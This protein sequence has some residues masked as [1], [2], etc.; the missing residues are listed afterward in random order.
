MTHSWPARNPNLAGSGALQATVAGVGVV[1][2]GG[3]LAIG[4]P[5]LTTLGGV[6]AV[7]AVAHEWIYAISTAGVPSLAQPATTDLSDV[8]TPASCTAPTA[9][10]Q[11]PADRAARRVWRFVHVLKSISATTRS[12]AQRASSAASKIAASKPET[13]SPV[14]DWRQSIGATP[15]DMA[16]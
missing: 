5:G 11:F 15:W 14:A 9:A 10:A 12:F 13:D 7:A 16:R 8:A 1:C 2:T 4:A 3:T 6:E